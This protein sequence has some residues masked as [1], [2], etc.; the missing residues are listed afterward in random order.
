MK[1]RGSPPT[2]HSTGNWPQPLPPKACDR[3]ARPLSSV[4]LRPVPCI[5]RACICSDRARLL[6]V[7]T[8][9]HC[10][11]G[12]LCSVHAAD[13]ALP[14]QPRQGALAAFPHPGTTLELVAWSSCSISVTLQNHLPRWPQVLPMWHPLSQAVPWLRLV[15]NRCPLGE[16]SLPSQWPREGYPAPRSIHLDSA[17][18]PSLA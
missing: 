2:Q 17:P 8:G 3:Q 16:D 12:G 6:P 14:S 15:T 10:F 4:L 11:L 1:Q 7:R 13:H 18:P 5:Y 9:Q